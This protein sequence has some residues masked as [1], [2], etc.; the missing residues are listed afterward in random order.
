MVGVTVDYG[1]VNCDLSQVIYTSEE[2]EEDIRET[3]GTFPPFMLHSM[4]HFIQI[5][6]I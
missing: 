6:N 5:Q 3:I 2:E 4:N 1:T